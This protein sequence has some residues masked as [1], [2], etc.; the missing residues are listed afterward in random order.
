M[1][2]VLF[3]WHKINSWS[4][5]KTVSFP[6]HLETVTCLLWRDKERATQRI[7]MSF[8]LFITTEIAKAKTMMKNCTVRVSGVGSLETSHVCLFPAESKKARAKGRKKSRLNYDEY[9]SQWKA[10]INTHHVPLRQLIHTKRHIKSNHKNQWRKTPEP[11]N[12]DHS[13]HYEHNKH[14]VEQF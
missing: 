10:K 12:T 6:I 1:E 7:L 9:K 3:M 13:P 14:T 8:F 5:K 11:G 4:R 2:R